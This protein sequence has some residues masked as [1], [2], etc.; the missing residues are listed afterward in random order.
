MG[1]RSR[2]RRAPRCSTWPSASGP[3]PREGRRRRPRRRPPGRPAHARRATTPRIEIVTARDP[4]AGE[5]IRHS[6]EHVMAD[7][8]KRLFPDAQVDV[9]RTDHAEKF[10]YDFQVERPFTPED[11]ARIEAEMRRILAEDAPF[12]REVVTREEARALFASLGEELKLSRLADIPEGE[13]ITLFRHGG[14]VD[15]CRGPHVQRTGADRR[16]EA[17]RGRRR[18]LARRRSATRCCSASTAPPS[19][20]RRSSTSTSSGIEEAKRR[21]HRRVGAELDLFHLDPIAPGSP[22][23]PAEGHDR[24]QRPRRLRALALPEVRLPG[25]DGPA[26]R[27]RRALQDARATTTSSTTTCSGSRATRARSSASSR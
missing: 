18:V 25:G 22:V 24:L 9:G 7:A 10:Q 8:V 21:D 11:L 1:G 2:C 5:V 13:P 14:F 3:R 20:R 15:L 6:A 27:A 4:A 17:P 26:G 23:L 12:T 16:G 19:R